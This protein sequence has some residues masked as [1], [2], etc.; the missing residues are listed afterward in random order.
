MA[1]ARR[2]GGGVKVNQKRP[3]PDVRGGHKRPGGQGRVLRGNS[4]A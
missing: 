2:T 1:E 4:T 3:L